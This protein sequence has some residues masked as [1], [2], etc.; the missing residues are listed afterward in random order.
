MLTFL[1]ELNY[2]VLW[3]QELSSCTGK[4]LADWQVIFL[5]TFDEGI[6]QQ[7]FPVRQS[8]K[9]MTTNHYILYSLCFQ[10]S[11]FNNLEGFVSE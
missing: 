8:C 9:V 4:D 11:K 1:F 10:F 3:R 7:A 5:Y 6:L 2:K